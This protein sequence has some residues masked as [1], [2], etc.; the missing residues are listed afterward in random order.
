M[1]I[2][3]DDAEEGQQDGM[4]VGARTRDFGGADVA[5]GARPVLADDR[6]AERRAEPLG[7]EPAEEI[8][9]P[10]RR[11]RVDQPD[12]LRRETLRPRGKAQEREEEEG[13][14]PTAAQS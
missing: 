4:A 13:G 7:D 12:G 14:K 3:G 8:E 9:R 11:E 1:R 6:L 10:A 2:A 5:G